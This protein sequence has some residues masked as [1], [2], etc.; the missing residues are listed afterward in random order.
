LEI[1]M[2]ITLSSIA[3]AI[4]V[5]LLGAGGTFAAKDAQK[6]S[7]FPNLLAASEVKG[8]NVKNLQNETIGDINEL[9]IEP[10]SGHV[11]FAVVG[12]GG[13]LGVGGTKVAVPWGAFQISKEGDKPKYVLDADKEH[14]KNAPKVEGTNYDRLYTREDAEPVFIYWH[15]EWVAEP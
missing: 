4:T 15:E 8:A 9:L 11:R 6:K 5:A 13:F 7:T 3:V 12:V 2:K 10:A 14:L 1:T